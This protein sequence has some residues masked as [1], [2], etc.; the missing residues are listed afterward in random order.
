MID[1][2]LRKFLKLCIFYFLIREVIQIC[3]LKRILKCL[4]IDILKEKV[5]L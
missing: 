5:E 1:G 2:F 3:F 4:K